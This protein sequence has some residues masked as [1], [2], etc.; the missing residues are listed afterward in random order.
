MKKIVLDN[1]SA[2]FLAKLGLYKSLEKIAL[3]TTK[4]I[5]QEI[6]K[7][8]EAGYRDA[9]IRRDMIKQKRISVEEV[10]DIALKEKYQLG[11][12]DRSV[13]A[14]AK[15]ER[16]FLATED[17][18]IRKIARIEGVQV[19][20]TATLIYYLYRKNNFE[21]KQALELL[22]LLS[23]WGYRKESIFIIKEKLM[24]NEK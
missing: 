24:V 18:Q 9:F 15:K 17:E 5:E 11:E 4:E 19:T 22:S 16:C 2:I 21:K 7:G 20:N 3:I 10:K 23:K 12:A 8:V 6:N 14:L 13:I 1:S